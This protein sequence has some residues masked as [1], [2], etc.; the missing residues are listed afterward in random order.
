MM[1]GGLRQVP[2]SGSNQLESVCCGRILPRDK[3]G[4]DLTKGKRA[5]WGDKLLV[6]NGW[7]CRAPLLLSLLRT[8]WL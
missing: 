4:R 3:K 5:E 7:E 2:L 6:V 1:V 8:V